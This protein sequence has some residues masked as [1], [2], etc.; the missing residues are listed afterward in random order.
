MP[1]LLL[2]TKILND[3]FPQDFQAFDVDAMSLG[4]DQIG[5][6]AA[7]VYFSVDSNSVG[8]PTSLDFDVFAQAA[9]HQHAADIFEALDAEP[10]RLLGPS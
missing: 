6:V 9:H 10:S 3:L 7:A 4:K 1:V 8:F 2:P 5:P